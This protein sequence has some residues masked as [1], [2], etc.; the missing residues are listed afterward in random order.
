M[1][2]RVAEIRANNR[3]WP[4]LPTGARDQPTVT[5]QER[6]HDLQFCRVPA[7]DQKG[8][9]GILETAMLDGLRIGDY[10]PD[11]AVVVTRT[12]TTMR[13]WAARAAQRMRT[14]MMRQR[15]QATAKPRARPCW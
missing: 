11:M 15:L 3:R 13:Y 8:H 1:R 14:S 4:P 12:M 9:N 5:C 7:L 6:T 2:T 10:N